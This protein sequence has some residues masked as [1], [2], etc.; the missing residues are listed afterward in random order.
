MASPPQGDAHGTA[1]AAAGDKTWSSRGEGGAVAT[2]GHLPNSPDSPVLVVQ[3]QHAAAQV[4]I[5]KITPFR[6][7]PVSFHR[8]LVRRQSDWQVG[9]AGRL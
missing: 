4:V 7:A 8:P 9:V 1:S 3:T 6:V 5:K 2:A